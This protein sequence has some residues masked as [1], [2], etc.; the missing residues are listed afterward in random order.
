MFRM[1]TMLLYFFRELVFDSKE[2]YDYKSK[3]FNI[4]KVL[5]FVLLFTS[6]V[7]NAVFVHRIYTLAVENLKLTRT[8]EEYKVKNPTALPSDSEEKKSSVR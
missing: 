5:V 2:E 7:T 8:I 1:L 6:F 4:R 3:M